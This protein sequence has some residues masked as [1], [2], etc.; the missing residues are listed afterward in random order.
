M[1]VLR[2]HP[3]SDVYNPDSGEM[4][5]IDVELAVIIEAA[6]KLGIR[7]VQCCQHEME[8]DSAWIQYA[9]TADA[10]R[11][12]AALFGEDSDEGDDL[13]GR[14]RDWELLAPEPSRS[15]LGWRWKAAP[16]VSADG[17]WAFDVMVEFPAS[18][19]PEVERRI[20]QSRM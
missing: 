9:S 8:S 20:T 14:Q 2:D 6:W 17:E 11:F 13:F 4:V 7:T 10:G 3:T 15:R 18:D 5:E 19:L 16:T 1:D 12:L